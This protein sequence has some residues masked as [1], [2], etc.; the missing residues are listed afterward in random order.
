[1]RKSS[2]YL[3]AFLEGAVLITIEL[4]TGQ[5]L[6]PLYGA[7]LFS[8]AAVIGVVVGCMALGY[9][10]GARVAPERSKRYITWILY[11]SAIYLLLLAFCIP[12]IESVL[13]NSAR[14]FISLFTTIIIM[15]AVPGWLLAMLPPMLIQH[16]SQYRQAPGIASGNIFFISTAGAI[17][18]CFVS[19]FLLLPLFGILSTMKICALLLLWCAVLVALRR[20]WVVSTVLLGISIVLL[21]YPRSRQRSEFVKVL[22]KSEGIN[23]QLMVIDAPRGNIVGRNYARILFVNRMGQA[24]VEKGTG[25]PLWS[26]VD[27]MVYLCGAKSKAPQVLVLGLGGGTLANRLISSLHAQVDVVEFDP[28]VVE[29]AKKYFGLNRQV[30][31]IID[32]ARHYLNTCQKQYDYILFDLFKGEVPASHVLTVE[33]LEKSRARLRPDGLA[34]INYSGFITG[35]MGRDTRAVIKTV[36]NVFGAEGCDVLFT[37][38]KE[39]YRN[40]IVVGRKGSIDPDQ[41]AINL[42]AY[43][44]NIRYAVDRVKASSISLDDDMLL[45]DN[46]PVLEYLHLKPGLSWRKDY[47][48]NFTKL[49]LKQGIPLF[50]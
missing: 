11:I 46:Q 37:P 38:E 4:L 50:D 8:W 20:T 41:S 43:G 26:Y 3:L 10:S 42:T 16:L 13:Y 48:E 47:Y 21:A 39:P 17:A 33:A 18:A 32:D 36:Q 19:G 2:L 49:Y 24:F 31:I 27:Y 40:S 44:K 14:V 22:E 5:M 7:S 12:Y 15:A 45:T 28:R 35:E 6:A 23:G 1:M 29:V 30:K 25:N 9:L 34:A